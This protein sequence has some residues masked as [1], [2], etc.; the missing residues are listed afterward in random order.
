MRPAELHHLIR[1]MTDSELAELVE[2]AS[3]EQHARRQ[4]AKYD[5]AHEH[6]KKLH[7]ALMGWTADN[8]YER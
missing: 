5:D 3:Y 7:E 4:L 2:V 8:G 6:A 1:E